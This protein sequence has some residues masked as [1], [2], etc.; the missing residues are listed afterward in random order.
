MAFAA[1][2]R[3]HHHDPPERFWLIT[4][5][6]GC[7]VGGMVGAA[8]EWLVP[9]TAGFS[10]FFAIVALGAYFAAYFLGGWH[11]FTHALQELRGGR[12]NID[13]LMIA[14]AVGS[15]CLGHWADGAALLFLFS[16]SHTMEAIILGRTRKAIS[17]LMHL[18]PEAAIRLRDGVEEQVAVAELLPG[19]LVLVHP[20]ER[21]PAD[22]LIRVGSTSVDESPVN[23]ESIPADK[24]P[25][26]AV[27]AGTLNQQGVIHV[28]VTR[29]A[30]QSTLARMVQLV[31]EA[32][33]Q[34]ANSQQ[35]T[36]W[37]GE[38]YSWIVLALAAATLL[39]ARVVTS[40]GWEASFYRMMTVLV[41]ASPCAVVIS[42]PAAI[43]AAISSA[44]RGGVLFKGGSAI[45]RA[46]TLKGMAFDKTGTLTIGRPRVVTVLPAVDATEIEV[47]Q[48]AAALEVHSEHPLA[49]AI[50]NAAKE[51]GVEFDPAADVQA[52]TGCGVTGTVRGEPRRVGKMSWFVEQGL[53]VNSQSIPG[54]EAAMQRGETVVGV[55]RD[56][57]WIGAVGIADTLRPTA[58]SC[59]AEL[60][61]LEFTE[62]VM[63]TGDAEPVARELGRRLQL[64]HRAA[65]L[66]AEKLLAIRQLRERVG[67]VGMI[68]DGMNDAPSLAA[69]DLGFSLGGAGT[70]VALETADVIILADDL[71]RLPYAIAL[72]RRSQQIIRQNLVFAFGVMLSLFVAAMLVRLPLPLA[73]LGH[74]GSTVL[75]ILNGLRLLT[76]PRP[77]SPRSQDGIQPA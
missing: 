32:Q 39:G 8:L 14:A 65:L 54:V 61:T 43:L 20:G 75:V 10:G 50:V 38:R 45:E 21:L 3:A 18:T 77:T 41:V 48:N 56:G 36:E 34:R 57:R 55:T 60:R 52:V 51:R 12:I 27:F 22:G 5:T 42:I 33:S 16:L 24:S 59:L 53:T 68:G 31:E 13:L 73:V 69:A 23:G 4:Q 71:R 9:T 67:P 62:L 29:A 19:D 7:L 49:K 30:G 76:F 35:F 11:T 37:F 72:A 6:V 66:P 63:L 17:D 64:H 40:E 46:A 15:A 74:E 25:G 70:D 26:D 44:A 47:L 1:P 58:A 28:E 2:K